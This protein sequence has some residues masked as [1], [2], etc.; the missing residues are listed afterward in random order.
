MIK[1]I[2]FKAGVVTDDSELGARPR[3]TDSDRIRFVRGL[4]QKIGGWAKF[5]ANSFAGICRGMLTWIA[6]DS[7]QRIAVG[8]HKKLYTVLGD[9]FYNIT[10]TRETGTLG[11]DPF[12]TTA[13]S[14]MVTVADTAH[15]NVAGDYVKFS[16]ATAVGGITID[17]EYVVQSVPSA[18]SY[19]IQHSAS[20]SSSATGGGASVAYEYEIHIGRADGGLGSGYGV[21]GYG[22]GTYGTARSSSIIL[23]PRVWTLDQWGQ[24]LVGCPRDGNIYEW[25]LNTATRAALLSNAP[26]SNIGIFVT[27]EQHLVALGAGGVDMKVEWCDQSDNTVWTPS[28]QNTAGGRTLTGGSRILFGLRARGT[29]AL[30]TDASVWTMTFVGGQD[31][32]GFRQAAAGAAGI[33]GP[34][35]AAEIQGT[36]FWMGLNDFF[37]FDGTVR[38]IPNS[39]NIRRHVFDNLSKLQKDKCFCWVNS[40]FS[41]IW[42]FYPTATEI[43]RYVKFNWDEL[44]WDVGTLVRTAGVDLGAYDLPLMAGSNGYIYQHESGNDDDGA[45]MNEYIVSSPFM[46]GDGQ[47]TVEVLSIMPDFQTLTGNLR[48]TLLTRYYPQDDEETRTIGVTKSNSKKL[49]V[50]ASGRQARLKASSNETGTDWKL[51][52]VRF[53]LERGGER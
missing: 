31:V 2:A 21:G 5:S 7:V 28:D 13:G 40:L 38:P 34:R 20:A 16:G 30:F 37:M 43:D 46:L 33:I 44:E 14:A 11:T 27:E 4:P 51:G 10:P 35:A 19:T 25:Q 26:T 15:A 45:A 24:Y 17:G 8:T 29:N 6:A 1:E 48:L 36:V 18:D 53:E 49:D 9:D 52:T 47:Y 12:T 23:P 39:K 41:E 32:F 42:W 3:W 50:R 22:E